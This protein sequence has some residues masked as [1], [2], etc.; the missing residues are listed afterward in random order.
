MPKNAKTR[1]GEHKKQRGITNMPE[2]I[3]RSSM[4]S[5]EDTECVFKSCNCKMTRE[6][7]G[8]DEVHRNMYDTP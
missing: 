4:K 7:E 6:E 3:E 8:W 2:I 1:S 5:N